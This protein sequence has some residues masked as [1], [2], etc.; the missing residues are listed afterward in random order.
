M[1]S[2]AKEGVWPPLKSARYCKKQRQRNGKPRGLSHSM[3]LLHESSINHQRVACAMNELNNHGISVFE[4][5]STNVFCHQNSRPFWSKQSCQ[6]FWDDYL[7]FDSSLSLHYDFSTLSLEADDK[8]DRSNPMFCYAQI[9]RSMRKLLKRTFTG[10]A[11]FCELE[12]LVTK[13]LAPKLQQPGSSE[14]SFDFSCGQVLN[15]SVEG[16]TV[17][18]DTPFHRVWLHAICRY[19]GLLSQSKTVDN[20]RLVHIKSS[21]AA[22]EIVDK[23]QVTLYS[24][25]KS[26]SE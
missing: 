7:E 14:S 20:S 26:F 4:A 8:N 13:T 12:D 3:M 15:V 17:K 21:A 19:Y 18:L 6:D 22:A 16:A 1:K 2:T 10:A 9:N 25:L 11:A 5:S 24:L 23:P